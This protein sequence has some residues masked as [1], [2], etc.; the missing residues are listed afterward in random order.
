MK[1]QP[2]RVGRR[3][4]GGTWREA[5]DAAAAERVATLDAAL[6]LCLS[7]AD[8]VGALLDPRGPLFQR[9]EFVGDSLLDVAATLALLRREHWGDDVADLTF[10]RQALVSD[11]ALLRAARHA[12]LPAVRGFAAGSQRLGDRVEA[13]VGAGWVDAGVTA[14]V[15]V[16]ERLV[17]DPALGGEPMLP[18]RPPRHPGREHDDDLVRRAERALGHAFDRAGWL[19][20]A[21]EPGPQRRRLAQ[22]GDGALE[23]AAAC[24]LYE[25]HPL[26]TEGDLTVLRQ[27]IGSNHRLAGVAARLGLAAGGVPSHHHRS[28]GTAQRRESDRAA[29]DDL[30]A[31]VGA[32]VMDAGP[33][34][35]VAAGRRLLGLPA[36]DLARRRGHRRLLAAGRPADPDEVRRRGPAQGPASVRSPS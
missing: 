14:A 29:A 22:L 36:E 34:A 3:A 15:A 30:Q 23:A 33:P 13:C 8:L 32:V 1:C 20:W 11:R 7:D 5:L 27:G 25:L 17:V 16:A 26:A 12:R 4:P 2:E 18:V 19:E 24:A 9:L 28:D 35:G 10:D 6:G 31:L 21:L